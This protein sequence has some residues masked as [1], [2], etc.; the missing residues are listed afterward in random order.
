MGKLFRAAQEAPAPMAPPAP[1]PAADPLAGGGGGMPPMPPMGMPTDPMAAAAPAPM[2]PPP[3][4]DRQEIIGPI[5][6]PS[7]MFYDMDLARYIQNNLQLDADALAKKVWEA[8]GGKPNGQP[9][10]SKVGSRT[11]S[12]TEHTPEQAQAERKATENSKWKRLEA[13]KTIADIVSY[14]DLG[15]IVS[16]LI[17]GV[18]QKVIT[19][20]MAPPGGAAMASNRARIIIAKNLEKESLFK[21]SDAIIKEIFK[22]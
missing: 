14:D 13:G 3:P 20:S 4:G 8:Y 18:I 17:F 7:Q 15:K 1:P 10:S 22:N 16:G 9:D 5:S 11:D 19:Q 12:Y 6:S 2:P 21:Q